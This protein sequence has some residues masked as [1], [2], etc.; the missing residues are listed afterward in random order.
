MSG[1][2]LIKFSVVVS[3]AIIQKRVQPILTF[4]DRLPAYFFFLP[5]RFAL[6]EADI[7]DGP[8]LSLRV[9]HAFLAAALKFAFATA[10]FTSY[11]PFS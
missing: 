7:P 8:Y 3:S 5:L 2:N 1:T 10:L 4:F 9:S 6:A 11:Q